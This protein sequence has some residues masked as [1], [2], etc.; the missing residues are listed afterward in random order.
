MVFARNAG[1]TVIKR[2]KMLDMMMGE[3]RYK[4]AVCGAAGKSTTTGFLASVL[5]AAN[6]DPSVIVG[7]VFADGESG[8]RIGKG[9]Y[10]IAEADEYDKS[11]LEMSDIN[12]AL[13]TGIEAEHLDTYK[14]FE[15]VKD[16]FLRFFS[17]VGN[18]GMAVVCIDSEGVRDVFPRIGC[19]KISYGFSA[20][21]D[22]RADGVKYENGKTVFD[23]YRN[24]N[25]LGG[26]ELKLIGEHNVLNALGAIVGGL[27]TGIPFETAAR[28]VANFKGIKRRIEKIAEVAGVTVISDYAH[29]PTKISATLSALQKIKTKRIITVFQPHTFTRVR[30][31][32]ENFAKS[33]EDGSD[34]VLLTEIYPAREKPIEGIDEKCIAKF[35]KNQTSGT[36]LKSRVAQECGKIAKSGDIIAVLGAGNINDEIE[37]LLKELKK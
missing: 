20:D 21:A 29:H 4:L 12:L 1:K 36:V 33:L 13:C 3:N 35:F 7:G 8:T 30:D 28:G 6:L 22:Y 31:F 24:G 9:D 32:A 15:G 18:D 10:F 27:Q 11:F 34:Y 17:G 14:S 37:N 26:V 19:K 25:F 23:V 5:E 16:G 2:A